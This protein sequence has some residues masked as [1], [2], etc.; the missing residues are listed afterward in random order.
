MIARGLREPLRPWHF[1]LAANTV[2][3]IGLAFVL[4]RMVRP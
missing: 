1:V 3:L 4:R 2:A